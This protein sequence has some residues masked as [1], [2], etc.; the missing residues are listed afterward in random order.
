MMQR[1]FTG[2]DRRRADA[3][4]LLRSAR[5]ACAGLAPPMG[6]AAAT[7]ETYQLE[8]FCG[9]GRATLVAGGAVW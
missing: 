8:S 4:Y 5:P 3:G 7:F 9:T 2:R 6:T 1:T